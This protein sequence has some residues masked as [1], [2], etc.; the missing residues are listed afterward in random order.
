MSKT[1]EF[2][3]ELSSPYS[4]L[5]ATQLERLA[6][7]EGAQILW[8][9]MVL[10]AVF[11][12][13][14]NRPPAQVQTKAAYLFRDLQRWSERYGVPFRFPSLFPINAMAAHRAILAAHDQADEPAARR[15]ALAL[16][17]AYWVQD[18]DISRPEV[19]A[20]VVDEADLDAEAIA[21]G[22]Q[23]PRIKDRLRINTDEAVARGVFGAPTLFVGD[24]MFWGNDRLDFVRE[25]LRRER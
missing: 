14:G 8:R 25:A 17:R 3:F 22:M 2:F 21:A 24:E 10:G 15:L 18:R 11:K 4:Y 23:D 16:Y 12:E 7:E 6:E 9:P 5:A 13:Q 1:I 19:V 20:E